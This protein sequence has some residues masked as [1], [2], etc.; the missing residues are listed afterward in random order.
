MIG[1]TT[2]ARPYALAAF[3]CAEENNALPAW[4]AM[5]VAAAAVA[6]DASAARLM[7]R[8]EITSAQLSSLFC[9]VLSAVLDQEKKN[10]ITLLA[11]HKR[12]PLLPG[13]AELFKTYRAAIEKILAVRV[14]TAVALDEPMQKKLIAALT[15]RLKQ[16]VS[17]VCEIDPSLLGGIIVRTEDLVMDGSVQGQL[18]RLLNSLSG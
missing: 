13:I 15:A 8:P 10:F 3:E 18:G 1:I 17:L 6:T 12:L 9:D 16:Q 5:L 4:E 7:A 11:E 14:T 2:L